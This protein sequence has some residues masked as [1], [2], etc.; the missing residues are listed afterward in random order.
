MAKKKANGDYDLVIKEKSTELYDEVISQRYKWEK[1][2]KGFWVWVEGVLMPTKH[3]NKI[4]KQKDNIEKS[5]ES[6]VDA[7]CSAVEK[8]VYANINAS[9]DSIDLKNV[10]ANEVSKVKKDCLPAKITESPKTISSKST[11]AKT[12]NKKNQSVKKFNI[13]ETTPKTEIEYI[14]DVNDYEIS[15][16]TL[17][18]YIGNHSNIKIPDSV[19]TIKNSAFANCS[20]LTSIEIPDSVTTI[21]SSGYYSDRLFYGCT[22]LKKVVLGK[23][24]KTITESMF[25]GL[26]IEEI[27]IPNSVTTIQKG[28]FANCSKLKSIVI[29]DSVTTIQSGSYYSDSL[30]YGCNHLERIVLKGIDKEKL[31]KLRARLLKIDNS[32][33][34]IIVLI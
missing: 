7:F 17:V 6:A 2:N 22:S 30:F 13:I 25:A 14:C 8:S 23:G 33:E 34:D 18:K 11:T 21:P 19:T 16:K 27:E 29:P 10:K 28:A 5:I 24:I 3:A 26:P 31:L 9:V 4:S 20:K 12:T 1:V 15:G 32:F